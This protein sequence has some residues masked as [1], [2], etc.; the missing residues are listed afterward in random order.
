MQECDVF[1]P[2][3]FGAGINPVTIPQ[4]RCSIVAGAANNQLADEDRDAALLRERDIL[5][6][7]D[8]VINAGGLIHVMSELE[9]GGGWSEEDAA[10][11][12][13]QTSNIYNT[14][15]RL[16]TIAREDGV[17]PHAAARQ[18]ANERIQ[19]ARDDVRKSSSARKKPSRN[20]KAPAK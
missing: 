18:M 11:V 20:G 16:L 9:A 2:C 8:Y 19:T 7:V 13:A 12:K 3:A 4:L 1:S 15:K 10:R 5:Y 14:L 6:A 17:S